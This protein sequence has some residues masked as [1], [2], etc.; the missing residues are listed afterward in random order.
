MFKTEQIKKD[1]K[2]WYL[3]KIQAIELLWKELRKRPW[4]RKWE[5]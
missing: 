2:A 5:F 4:F 1:Y 3:D